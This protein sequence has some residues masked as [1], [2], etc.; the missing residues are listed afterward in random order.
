MVLATMLKGRRYNQ[1]KALEFG[2]G[3][4]G[5]AVSLKEKPAGVIDA[6]IAAAGSGEL[7]AALGFAR[8][9]IRS[10]GCNFGRNL[11]LPGRAI[12]RQ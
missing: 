11:S 5:I 4:A 1:I 3:T 9:E 8:T 10:E 7:D 6:S 2:K 12:G